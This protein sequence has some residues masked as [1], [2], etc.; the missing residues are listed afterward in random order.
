MIEGLNF[1]DGEWSDSPTKLTDINPSDTRDIV[2]RFAQASVAE[3]DRAAAASRR[4]FPAWAATT[5]LERHDILQRVG[6]EILARKEELGMLL[7]SEEGKTLAEGIGECVRAA[8]IFQYFAG[9]CLRQA[10]EVLRSIRPG[11][12]VSVVREPVGVIGVI[13]PWN[14]PIAI[15]AWK[16][17]PALAF[18]NCVVFKPS[19]IAP[20]TA[21]RLAEILALSGL[22]NGVFN[23]VN[24]EGKDV[25]A[26]IASS[27]KLDGISFTGSVGVGQT[28]ARAAVAGPPMRR[29]QL[30]MGG[31]NALVVLDDANIE[32]AVE[33]AVNGGFYSTGQRCTASSRVIVTEG[34]YRRFIERLAQRAASLKVGHALDPETEVGPVVDERQLE[35]NLNYIDI[36]RNEGARLAVGGERQTRETPG[37]YFSPAVFTDVSPSMRIAREEIFGPIVAVIPA[38]DYAEALAIANDSE[39]GLSAGICT[40]SLAHAE[41]FKRNVKAGMVMINVPTAGVDFHVPFG[42]RKLSNYGP[43]EQGRQSHEFFTVTKT[44]YLDPMC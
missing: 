27:P 20:A 26:A 8:Q 9:E 14:F 3:V 28:I 21:Y 44:A 5:P 2:G 39:F 16:V 1:I 43:R 31:K 6:A 36:G 12:D 25:G 33:C 41:H 18:G 10:G 22:P 29:L 13:T 4:A 19:E 37:Y 7:S 17:A 32:R 15:P 40:S 11:L 24:G 38:R 35:K 34:V 42:G 23:L 30:E